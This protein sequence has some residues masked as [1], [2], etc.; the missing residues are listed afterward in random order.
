MAQFINLERRTNVDEIFDKLY[1]DIV[2][3]KLMP[4][5]KISEAEIASQFSVSRQPVRDAFAR[6]GNMDLLLIRPQKATVV[7]KFSAN[8]IAHARFIRTAIEVEVLRNAIVKWPETD[9]TRIRDIMD[10]QAK[11]IPTKDTNRFHE[12]DL[13][14]H[15]ALCVAAGFETAFEI[16]SEMKTRVDR[17]GR[18]SLEQPTEMNVLLAD[19]RRIIAALDDND[20]AAL[21]HAIRKHLGR[22]DAFIGRIQ[23]EHSEYFE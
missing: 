20:T 15:N 4:G 21:D 7:R 17:L 12:L 6:L 8:G 3:L 2:T 10:E 16:I 22:L 23:Q 18:L 13:E 11:A 9:T 19:H 1:S 5:T 14:F